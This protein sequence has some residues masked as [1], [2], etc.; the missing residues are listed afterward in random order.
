MP[1]ISTTQITPATLANLTTITPGSYSYYNA[2]QPIIQNIRTIRNVAPA[3][4]TVA[5]NETYYDPIGNGIGKKVEV[6]KSSFHGVESL[7]RFVVSIDTKSYTQHGFGS[8]GM[9][10]IKKAIEQNSISLVN[11]DWVSRGKDKSALRFY[12]SNQIGDYRVELAYENHAGMNTESFYMF[13]VRVGFAA[14]N[15]IIFQTRELEGNMNTIGG[16]R[17][18]I[19]VNLINENMLKI[20]VRSDYGVVESKIVAIL[21]CPQ[22]WY[23]FKMR[24]I[25]HRDYPLIQMNLNGKTIYQTNQQFGAYNTRSHYSKFGAY[26]PQQAKVKGTKSTLLLFKDFKEYHRH[27][28]VPARSHHRLNHLIERTSF[29][30]AYSVGIVCNT[31]KDQSDKI[32]EQLALA[33][34]NNRGLY[35]PPGK[36]RIDKNINIVSNSSII[37]SSNGNSGSTIFYG[38]PTGRAIEIG[39]T[40]EAIP[41]NNVVISDVIFD[42]VIVSFSGSLKSNIKVSYNAFI[43][44]YTLFEQAQISLAH[45]SYTVKGNVLMRGKEFP[46]VGINTYKNTNTTISYNYLGSLRHK[47]SAK[48]YMDNKVNDLLY[49]LERA[50]NKNE[51]T[52]DSDQGHYV[53]AWY[54][55]DKLES[56]KFYRNFI[57]GNTLQ[58]LYNSVTKNYDVKRDHIIYIK[59]YNDIDI[60]QNLFTGWPKTAHGQLKFR[61]AKCLYFVGNYLKE[62]SF[63]ARPYD[64]SPSLFM[65]ET[66]IFN[67]FIEDG[68][69]TYWQN[70]EDDNK[71]RIEVTGFYVFNNRFASKNESI[72]RITATKK[73]KSNAFFIVP[74]SN[75]YTDGKTQVISD[76]F[77]NISIGNIKD[78]LPESK[79]EFLDMNFIPLR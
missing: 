9:N 65:S 14:A 26:I 56:T 13:N 43:N 32:N 17:P 78:K 36:Y 24:V 63:D 27:F 35:F 64:I 38:K 31:D 51:I 59:H 79:N 66:Y 72:A 30:N 61:N 69:V 57:A 74:G 75:L 49:R 34:K 21:D 4:L 70:F 19:A 54:A 22:E 62:T 5:H 55:T 53:C 23:N 45:A 41:V 50:K 3:C 10:E 52:L 28:S 40:T 6:M 25:W 46:G 11:G 37:G 76:G 48:N 20:N 77:N 42:N 58:N 15:V 39:E 29:I 47:A 18:A 1:A 8:S 71:K 73:N 7:R 16:G 60:Y 2:T 33:A 68:R 67:N 44:S 12:L